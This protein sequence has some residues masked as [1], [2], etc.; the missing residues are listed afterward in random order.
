MP[1]SPMKPEVVLALSK[2]LTKKVV[3]DARA[4]VKDGEAF[5]VEAVLHVRGTVSVGEA[6]MTKQVN[7]LNPYILMQLALSKLNGVTID[8]FVAEVMALQA[9][10]EDED[11]DDESS[12]LFLF[13]EQ[14]KEAMGKL[15]AGVTQRRNGP[16]TFDGDVQVTG[17]RVAT[18]PSA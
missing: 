3:G 8:S 17:D 6:T 18:Q 16:V 7:K 1:I 4:L 5:D 13:K 10:L 14:V 11:D 15:T 9:K 12:P 2:M